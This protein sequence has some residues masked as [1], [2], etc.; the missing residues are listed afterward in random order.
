MLSFELSYGVAFVVDSGT[1]AYTADPPARNAFRS[2]RAH[3]VVVV[4]GREVNPLPHEDLFGLPQVAHAR[5]EDW[6]E[7]PQM[8]RLVLSH[9][10]YRDSPGG[11]LH[12]RT[13]EL[14]RHSGRLSVVDELIGAGEHV[15]ESLLHLAPEVIVTATGAASFELSRGD[16][17]AQ[18]AFWGVA[19]V[20][21]S[22]GW[23]SSEFG[24]RERAPVLVARAR[25]RLPARFGWAF[26][27]VTPLAT[28]TIEHEEAMTV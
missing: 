27:A 23:V 17:R 12:R 22:E 2:S 5:L 28:A 6:E 13:F 18:V 1:Y 15:A 20:V 9:D 11:V 16:A 19:D 3:N 7:S 24:A 26:A 14:D 21:V 10:G 4:D 8:T 25:R